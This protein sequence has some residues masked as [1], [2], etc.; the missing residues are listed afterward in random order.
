M[1]NVDSMLGDDVAGARQRRTGA[2]SLPLSE[3]TLPAANPSFL[4]SFLPFFRPVFARPAAAAR[5]VVPFRSV[6]S[7]S[8]SPLAQVD[9]ILNKFHFLNN[10]P[11]GRGGGGRRGASSAPLAPS[12][13]VG[14]W[15]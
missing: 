15:R 7:L 1:I 6:P 12:S 14:R 5:S 10:L 8:L 11:V 4:P 13:L 2:I 9:L 3:F